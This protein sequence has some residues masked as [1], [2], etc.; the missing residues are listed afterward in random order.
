MFDELIEKI[1]LSLDKV[2]QRVNGVVTGMVVSPFDPQMG[3]RLQVRLPIFND[4]VAWARVAVPM[5]GLLHGS[6]FI[7]NPGD[8]VLVA[9]EHGDTNVPYIVG[10]LWNMVQRPP[11]PSPV[12]QIRGIRTPLGNQI[13]FTEVPPTLVLQN[14]PTPP[15]MPAPPAPTGVPY[16]SVVLGPG[17]VQIMAPTSISL[18][19][20]TNTVTITP[21]GITIAATGPVNIASTTEVSIVAPK[22]TIG[23]A[24]DCSITAGTI[25]LNS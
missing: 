22:V 4:L 13:T 5:A 11:M 9:F 19:V 15:V 25:R 16:N 8:E 3:G 7:P 23:P 10:S 12:P 18:I 6:Y 21:A 17:G 2:D 20:G 1:E 24:A 14:G